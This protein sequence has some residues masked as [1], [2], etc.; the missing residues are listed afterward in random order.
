MILY[1][2]VNSILSI[3]LMISLGY[4]LTHINWFQEN[5]A[6]IFSKIIINIS[7]PSLIIYNLVTSFA[8]DKLLYMW[9]S[10]IF[11]VLGLIFSY[12]LGRLVASLIGIPD[13]EKGIFTALFTFSNTVF[14]GMPVNLAFFGEK[15]IKIATLYYIAHTTFFWTV[16]IYGIKKDKSNKTDKLISLN[17]LKNIFSPVLIAYLFANIL[18]FFNL[19]LP[20]FLLDSA[21]YMSS[22]TTPLSMLFLGITLYNVEL[23]SLKLD[24]KLITI[25][26]GTFLLTPAVVYFI[27][28]LSNRPELMQKVFI[29]EAAMPV[30]ATTPIVAKEY[31]KNYEYAALVVGLTTAFS[32]F[33][34][35]FYLF[36]LSV[37]I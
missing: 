4:Y 20:S 3:F 29:L 21:E 12:L 36:I 9:S 10:L 31:G 35:P 27:V 32:I 7:L 23:G 14:I 18:I 16:G 6:A 8:K 37:I 30:M 24:K 22:M 13:D 2:A 34:I 5:T 25:L 15:S 17:N 33:M 28:S 26:L 11:P 1:D 19:S